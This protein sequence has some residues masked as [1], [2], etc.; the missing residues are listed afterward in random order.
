MKSLLKEIG[1]VSFPDFRAE[2]VYML[3]FMQREGLPANL[4]HWQ[5]TVD[6]MLRG[7]VTERPIYL[8]IDQSQV[9]A[10]QPQRR[11]GAHIDGYWVVAAGSHGGHAPGHKPAA[12]GQWDSGS[13]EW[14]TAS[15]SE[16]E[17]IVLASDVTASRAL[18]G[19]FDGPIG[20]GGDCS[21]L[22]LSGLRDV[23]LE[24][25][26]AYIGN[27][28]MVHESL[29]VALACRRTLVRLNLPGVTFDAP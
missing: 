21:H 5:A 13:G 6:A 29:P 4:S 22:N 15:F 12:S 20:D 24:S 18:V 16:P 11:P 9:A 27:V 17:A 7:I 1:P 3:P 26:R 8:M 2:R 25:G 19:D 10:G 14:K 28:T 23:P